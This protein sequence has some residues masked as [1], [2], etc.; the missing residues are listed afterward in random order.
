MLSLFYRFYRDTQS[1]L[2]LW[3]RVLDNNVPVAKVEFR[4]ALRDGDSL[5]TLHLRIPVSWI[6]IIIIFFTLDL[7]LS[8]IILSGELVTSLS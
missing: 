1:R 7:A 8:D 3:V 6:F 5:C 4:T 2:E